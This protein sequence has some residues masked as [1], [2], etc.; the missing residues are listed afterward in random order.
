MWQISFSKFS[1]VL[2]A[3]TLSSAIG[4]LWSICLGVSN[5]SPF[6]D[7]FSSS[8]IDSQWSL[9][10]SDEIDF[11]DKIETSDELGFVA[12]LRLLTELQ[13]F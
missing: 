5:L 11:S 10:S 6:L 8:E 13:K 3:C 12:R 1:T 2:P 9:E 7:I 4:N